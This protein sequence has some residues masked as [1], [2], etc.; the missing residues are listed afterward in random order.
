MKK[1]LTA[2]AALLACL[3]AFAACSSRVTVSLNRN[4]NVNTTAAY[5]TSFYEQLVYSV[6]YEPEEASPLNG[7]RY[8]DVT[9]TYTVTTEA[10]DYYRASDSL[11]VNQAYRLTSVLEISASLTDES[12]NVVYTFGGESGAPADTVTTTVYFRDTN[13]GLAP[14][15]S[16]SSYYSHTPAQSGDIFLYKYDTRIVYSA[17]ASGATITLTDRSAEITENTDAG[18]GRVSVAAAESG[19]IGLSSLT[20]NYSVFDS[21]QLIFAARGLTFSDGSSNTVTVVSAS[22]GN[23]S[24]TVACQEIVN[25]T[26][27]FTMAGN[28]LSEAEISTCAVN[29][30]IAGA[31]SNT[32]ATHTVDFANKSSTATANTYRN[33]PLRIQ[34]PVSYGMG[35]FVYAL[36]SAAYTAPA[37][38]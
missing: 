9:G 24:V 29:F 2:I 11:T 18:N 5:D 27:S 17:D 32:G 28:A 20:E 21:A 15:E 10:T 1:K 25:R 34:S 33:L 35:T 13:D 6:R 31:G 3:F 37:A 26:Y 14:L 7:L 30:T 8:A 22:G 36:S 4:W 38:E 19:E 16:T 12:G 23:S